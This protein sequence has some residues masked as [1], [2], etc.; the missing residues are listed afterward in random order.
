MV[1]DPDLQA[2]CCNLC[3]VALA[4]DQVPGHLLSKHKG[5]STNDKQLKKILDEL[6]VEISDVLPD[7]LL[8]MEGVPPFKGLKVWN[9]FA[10]Q[11]CPQVY[12]HHRSIHEHHLK[13]HGPHCP[14]HWCQVWFYSGRG[15][16]QI[17]MK[18]DERGGQRFGRRLAQ[19]GVATNWIQ[20]Q[21]QQ[22]WIPCIDSGQTETDRGTGVVT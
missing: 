17:W 12:Q 13:Q 19:A 5:I 7:P 20:Q 21:G 9:G 11:I 22:V 3:Q 2:L 4:P 8:S 14:S 18:A 15:S 16:G 1:V 10:C 6:E